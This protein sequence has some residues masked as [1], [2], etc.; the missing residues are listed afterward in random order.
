[1]LFQGVT[2]LVFWTKSELAQSK[3]DITGPMIVEKRKLVLLTKA[4]MC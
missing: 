4:K 3:L 1:M 2:Y